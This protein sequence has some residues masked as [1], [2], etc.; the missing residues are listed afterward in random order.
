[1]AIIVPHSADDA[2]GLEE[3]RDFCAERF[4]RYKLPK[5]VVI[6]DAFPRSGTGKIQKTVLREELAE[7]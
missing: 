1:M 6:R 5:D 4:A 7:G 3:I 2:P